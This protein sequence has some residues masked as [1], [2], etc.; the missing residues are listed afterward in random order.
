MPM[1]DVPGQT[2][3]GEPERDTYPGPRRRLPSQ[4]DRLRPAFT[5]AS[6]LDPAPRAPWTAT[7]Q[8]SFSRS[9]GGA[10]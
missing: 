10:K 4:E 8:P 6:P 5:V 2:R 7:L 3:R 9:L 1:P